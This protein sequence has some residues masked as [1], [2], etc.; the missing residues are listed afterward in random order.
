MTYFFFY[1]VRKKQERSTPVPPLIQKTPAGVGIAWIWRGF[2]RGKE[3]HSMSAR[4]WGSM[5]PGIQGPKIL[6]NI[7]FKA[8]WFW[9]GL[10][11]VKNEAKGPRPSKVRKSSPILGPA[12]PCLQKTPAGVGIAWFWRGLARGQELRSTSTPKWS[13]HLPRSK[14]S[15]VTL[16][17]HPLPSQVIL[18]VSFLSFPFPLS[19]PIF[20]FSH[21]FLFLFPF[22]F[23]L[24]PF[25]LFFFSFMLWQ[26]RLEFVSI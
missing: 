17:W 11:V 4:N 14:T 21:L 23:F 22:H 20:P 2:A 8:A 12:L 1:P 25:F 18:H 13:A 5:G 9:R 24:F 16:G 6:Q 19:F 10:R 3:L 26:K 15:P 7:S